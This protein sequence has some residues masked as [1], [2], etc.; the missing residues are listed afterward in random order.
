MRRGARLGDQLQTAYQ[1]KVAV[2]EEIET[3][4]GSATAEGRACKRDVIL[5]LLGPGR[6]RIRAWCLP[7][8]S[9][10]AGAAATASIA[11]V[12]FNLKR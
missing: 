2:E 6:L 7:H 9:V 5:L 10:A 8:W 3:L 11:V 1:E 12:L 4:K